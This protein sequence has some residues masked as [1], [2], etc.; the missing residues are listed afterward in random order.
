MARYLRRVSTDDETPRTEYE[1]IYESTLWQEVHP[2][3]WCV[4]KDDLLFL[5][6]DITVAWEGGLIPE[7][8][9]YENDGHND[10]ATGP[11]IYDVNEHYVLQRIQPGQSW[12]L[13]RNPGGLRCQIFTS[14]WWKEGIFEFLDR[15]IDAWPQCFHH[16][17]IC[18]LSNPQHD[19]DTSLLLTCELEDSPFAQALMCAS[20]LIVLP[21]RRGCIYERAWCVYEIWLAVE[22]IE[23]GTAEDLFVQLPYKWKPAKTF[24]RIF[25]LLTICWIPAFLI[26]IFIV[27]PW[28]GYLVGPFMWLL[29][30]Y[31]VSRASINFVRPPVHALL[32]KRGA[33]KFMLVFILSSIA[34]AG[35]AAG[36]AAY[37]LGAGVHHSDS[38]LSTGRHTAGLRYRTSTGFAWT[39]GERVACGLFCSSFF[40]M[41]S[42]QWLL[43]VVELVRRFEASYLLDFDTVKKPDAIVASVE[44]DLLRIR[45]AIRDSEDKIDKAIRTVSKVGWYDK[46]VAF[47]RT[48][49]LSLYRIRDGVNPFKIICG[50]CAWAFWFVTD[51][52]A[53]SFSFLGVL[54]VAIINTFLLSVVYVPTSFRRRYPSADGRYIW[55]VEA[56]VWCG[57][58]YALFSN[59]HVFFNKRAIENHAMFVS[60][61]SLFVDALLA[62]LLLD[63]YFYFGFHRLVWKCDAS[64][65]QAWVWYGFDTMADVFNIVTSRSDR[66]NESE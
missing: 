38:S 21:T 50:T 2:S 53:N 22:S 65:V 46:A 9:V 36:L 16:A 27:G 41:Y 34:W 29:L 37:E 25:P 51:L 43:E 20:Y 66:E 26:G 42:Y 12:A 40:L 6:D 57:V 11:S 61:F 58:A 54:V 7:N 1:Q 4:T 8:P 5:R 62:M 10:R 19:V 55:A 31:L 52:S 59:Y 47:N 63:I 35:L 3:K 39:A 17:Y 60:A 48:A 15:V 14:H 30:A 28:I 33:H 18:F 24:L 64:L 44:R 13:I 56:W 32:G 49:G 45:H 23:D